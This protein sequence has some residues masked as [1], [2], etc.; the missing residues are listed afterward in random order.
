MWHFWL[1]FWILL[2]VVIILMYWREQAFEAVGSIL[3]GYEGES[4]R[5][6]KLVC[7]DYE[8]K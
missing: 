7:E 1:F 3:W 2:A 6:L 5:V 4:E 8:E